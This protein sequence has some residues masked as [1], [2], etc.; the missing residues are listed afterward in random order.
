MH[1][2]L[3]LRR[4]DRVVLRMRPH[5]PRDPFLAETDALQA[6]GAR[7]RSASSRLAARRSPTREHDMRTSLGSWQLW[8]LL[9]AAFAALT[10]V[11]AEVCVENVN[12]DFATFIRAALILTRPL[13]ATVGDFLDTP[14]G[15]GGVNL[16]RPLASTVITTFIVALIVLLPRRAGRHL[17]AEARA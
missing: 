16:S 14:V 4:Q 3:P 2:G 6:N 7:P 11:F 12:P 1:G 5:H 10:A 15:D 13:G 8:A 17:G 9:L